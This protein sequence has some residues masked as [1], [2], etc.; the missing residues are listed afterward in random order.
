MFL[1]YIF[2]INRRDWKLE[3]DNG[4]QQK[5][6]SKLIINLNR[7]EDI[8]ERTFEIWKSEL[9]KGLPSFWDSMHGF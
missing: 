1:L 6:N 7:E 4:M 2:P 9:Q 5:K 3:E 8:D